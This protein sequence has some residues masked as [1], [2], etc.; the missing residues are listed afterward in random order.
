MNLF[1]VKYYNHISG[2]VDQVCRLLCKIPGFESGKILMYHH[3]TDEYVN[4]LESCKCTVERFT[5]IIL[6]FK[7]DGYRFITVDK[8]LEFIKQKSKE[9][10]VVITFDD[11]TEDMFLNAYPILKQMKIPFIVYV[12][13]DFLN[14]DGFINEKQ[15][16]ILNNESFCTIGSH[17][18]SHPMLRYSK[19]AYEE[20]FQSKLILEK[21]LG[22]SVDH[23]AYPYGKFGAVSLKNMRMAKN[24]G[25]KS[26]MGT[27]RSG[28]STRFKF[29]VWYLPRVV[30]K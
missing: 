6:Q 9:R 20:I 15:L 28:V 14:K 12:A 11:A 17:T 7:N 26:A 1:W 10:F 22:K 29:C 13:I 24:A 18:I 30:L 3:V 2:L 25:Y 8:L 21:K 19:N 5:E 27:V 23:F 16:E 4:T